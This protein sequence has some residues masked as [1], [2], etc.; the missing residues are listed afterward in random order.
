[1]AT[2]T[3]RPF[4]NEPTEVLRAAHDL[5]STHAAQAARFNPAHNGPLPAVV[6]LLHAELQHREGTLLP[7]PEGPEYTP[8]RTCGHIEP[9]HRP[10]SGPC[11]VCDCSA[12]EPSVRTR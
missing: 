10:D 5:A 6:D 12:Y 11:L 8:C 2:E 3:H 1:M 9:E 4:R 7:P